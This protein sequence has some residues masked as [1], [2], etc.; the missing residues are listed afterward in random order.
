MR[1]IYK[2]LSFFKFFFGFYFIWTSGIQHLANSLDN[3]ESYLASQS[4]HNSQIKALLRDKDA[5]SMSNMSNVAVSNREISILKS[6]EKANE[7]C[8]LICA[9]R[10]LDA[11]IC[12]AGVE[13]GSCVPPRHNQMGTNI[14]SNDVRIYLHLCLFILKYFRFL[15]TYRE[16]YVHSRTGPQL[17]KDFDIILAIRIQNRPLI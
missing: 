15:I 1:R 13:D 12:S 9:H 4:I 2:V 3:Y 16:L 7:F 8:S 5:D 6:R 14:A 17:L 10:L 11:I